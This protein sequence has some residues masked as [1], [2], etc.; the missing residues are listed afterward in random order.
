KNIKV[1]NNDADPNDP[2]AAT[3]VLHNPHGYA[4]KGPKSSTMFNLPLPEKGQSIEKKVIIRQAGSHMMIECDQHNYM[5]AFFQPVDN[6]YYAIVGED[7]T[8]SI[9]Q[10]PPGEYEIE[11]FHPTL[12]TQTAKITVAA[13]GAVTSDFSFSPK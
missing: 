1:T 8:F 3:G 13:G 4:I 12:G 6:P 10:V 9:D 5:R 2:K 7:G 11:A